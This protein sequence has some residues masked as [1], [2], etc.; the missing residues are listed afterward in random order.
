MQSF[1]KQTL[2]LV[3]SAAILAAIASKVDFQTVFDILPKL[4]APWAF[5]A[6]MLVALQTLPA[7]ARFSTV[8]SLFNRP[9]S[10]RD[11]IFI[12]LESLF[13]AQTFISFLGGDALRIWKV[14]RRGASLGQA[15]QAVTLDRLMGIFTNH[16]VLLLAL[17]WLLHA[18]APGHIRTVLLTLAAA[19]TAGICAFL[20]IGWQA[21]VVRNVVGKL[22]GGRLITLITHLSTLGHYCLVPSW[23]LGK[24][25]LYGLCIAIMNCGAFFAILRGWQVDFPT[26]V[27][28]ALIV[29]GVLEVAM[30]PVSIAG[31]GVREGATIAAFGA[32]GVPV[33]IAFGTSIVF[34]LMSLCVGLIGGGVWLIDPHK[35]TASVATDSLK[36]H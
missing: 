7:A 33:A 6:F 18:L 35:V 15:V 21:A 25:V 28:C 13:F 36:G 11:S 22:G 9:L 16:I 10:R 19:G 29:P 2:K 8:V 26:A 32:F 34:A 4:S 5:V 14:R 30:L 31:W 1:G 12:T 27:A 24:S 3:L 23:A 20:L 17:P